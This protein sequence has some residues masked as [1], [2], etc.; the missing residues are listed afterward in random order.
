MASGATVSTDYFRTM[1]IP[2]QRGRVFTESDDANRP[3][4]ALVNE[5]FVRRFLPDVNPMGRRVL[6]PTAAGGWAT[7]VGVVGAWA[8]T[9]YLASLLFEVS[10][11][12]PLTLLG[13][14]L[15]LGGIALLACLVPAWR[16]ARAD[17]TRALRN[18]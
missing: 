7:I 6:S 1:D 10:P 17:P 16:A 14:C 15:I 5:A 18:E 3:P 12:D 4:V 2:L 11:S 9:R 8:L 13:A